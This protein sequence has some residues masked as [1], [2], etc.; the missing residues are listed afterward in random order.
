MTKIEN[1]QK[2]T[3]QFVLNYYTLDYE[4]LLHKSKAQ[5]KFGDC[6]YYPLGFIL[7]K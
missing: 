2:T 4:I 5:W 7:G 6:W 3:L 1:I